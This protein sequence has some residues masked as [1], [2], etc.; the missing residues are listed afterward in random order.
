MLSF[1]RNT[2][3]QQQKPKG[4]EPLPL[5]P[6]IGKAP[7]KVGKPSGDYLE[8]VYEQLRKEKQDPDARQGVVKGAGVLF[9][10]LGDLEGWPPHSLLGLHSCC[11]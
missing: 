3:Q 2:I 6:K 8:H 11:C 7:A 4:S 10:G 9:A 1:I 5:S